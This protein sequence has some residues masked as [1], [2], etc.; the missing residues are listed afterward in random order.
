VNAGPAVQCAAPVED[1]RERV[2]PGAARK[3]GERVASCAGAAPTYD[4]SGAER[5]ARA[6]A[7]TDDDRARSELSK[8][9]HPRRVVGRAERAAQR[10][11]PHK[12]VGRGASCAGRCTDGRA[13]RGWIVGRRARCARRSTRGRSSGGR[14]LRSARCPQ[15]PVGLG[16]SC[17]RRCTDGRS[18]LCS[19]LHP[20]KTVG[21]GASCAGAAPTDGSSGAERAVQCAAPTENCRVRSEL[22]RWL[23]PRRSSS[24][25]R[26]AQ[27]AA[28]TDVPPTDGSSSAERAVQGAAPTD[29]PPMGGSSS[30]A[31]A[32]QCAAPTET[33][34]RGASCAV[35]CTDGSASHT[36][37]SC[38]GCCTDGNSSHPERAVQGA[39]HTDTSGARPLYTPAALEALSAER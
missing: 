8:A 14:E 2:D 13:T 25:E 33:V 32:V 24:A 18:G 20:R 16:A 36:G 30:A 35:R 12:P 4:P 11:V 38:A 17:A 26:A 22:R 10:A 7:L 27:A 34:G 21:Y 5:A 1:R 23:H 39:A 15:K 19:A 31:R 37:A 28:P 9:L 29:V 3:I 6:A